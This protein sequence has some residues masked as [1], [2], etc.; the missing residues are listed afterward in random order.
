MIISKIKESRKKAAEEGKNLD[1]EIVKRQEAKKV[2][3]FK[4]EIEKVTNT[5]EVV[6]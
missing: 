2:D 1:E 6:L 4:A 3:A 5:G